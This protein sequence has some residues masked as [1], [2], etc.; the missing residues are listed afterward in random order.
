MQ[1][2]EVL[3]HVERGESALT[4]EGA[5]RVAS[6]MLGRE[7]AKHELGH[8]DL[9]ELIEHAHP[10]LLDPKIGSDAVAPPLSRREIHKW[11]CLGRRHK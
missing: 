11:R 3:R 5:A 10:F 8:L 1:Q 9:R 6:E 2:R 4:P 7:V